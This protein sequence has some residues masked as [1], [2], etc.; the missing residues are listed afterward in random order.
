V[1][2][3]A[4]DPSARA[5]S[6]PLGRGLHLPLEEIEI[7][8]SRSSGPGGQHVNKTESRVAA[9][10]RV[11]ESRALDAETRARLLGALAARLT[12]DGTLRVVCERTRSQR[13]NRD[14]AVERLRRI[15]AAALVVRTP[16][17]KTAPTRASREGRLLDK[18]RRS[19]RKRERRVEF[20][21]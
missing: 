9:S 2:S 19:A 20:D 12:G 7:E 16:R 17:R 6:L 4:G 13:R 1:A 10:F 8:T 5:G 18:R 11:A 14:E 15:L 3:T 21:D